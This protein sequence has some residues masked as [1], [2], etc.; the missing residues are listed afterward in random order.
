MRWPGWGVGCDETATSSKVASAASSPTVF[1]PIPNTGYTWLVDVLKTCYP[2]IAHNP[3]FQPGE[4]YLNF[5]TRWPVLTLVRDPVESTVAMLAKHFT[6]EQHPPNRA[7]LMNGVELRRRV[8]ALLMSGDLA[9]ASKYQ[10]L[11]RRLQSRTP[12]L[13]TIILCTDTLAAA[14]P[15]VLADMGMSCGPTP[16]FF[17]ADAVQCTGA[18]ATLRQDQI[19]NIRK[20]KRVQYNL[21]SEFCSGWRSGGDSQAPGLLCSPETDSNSVCSWGPARG[22][23]NLYTNI[24]RMRQ[25]QYALFPGR[26]C[27]C[28]DLP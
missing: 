22:R 16:H 23:L 11:A 9:E 19:Q 28:K 10:G 18:Y 27:P 1:V 3:S 6:K 24:S 15:T 5:S 14:A 20:L 25:S 21:W 8:D 7:L 12:E 2:F 17:E 26:R 4:Y 13:H